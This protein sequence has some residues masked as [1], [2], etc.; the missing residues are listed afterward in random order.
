MANFI[1]SAEAACDLTKDLAKKYEV[2]VLNASSCV[3]GLPIIL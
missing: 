1:L 2:N 3:L